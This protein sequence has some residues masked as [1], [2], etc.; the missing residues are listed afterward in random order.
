MRGT[1]VRVS[2][3]LPEYI[4]PEVGELV[5]SAAHEAAVLSL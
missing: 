1:I 2:L 4:P 3:E 5:L